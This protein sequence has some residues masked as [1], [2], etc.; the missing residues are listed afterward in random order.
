MPPIQIRRPM[1]QDEKLGYNAIIDGYAIIPVFN[2]I[3]RNIH[4]DLYFTGCPYIYDKK[5]YRYQ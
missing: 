5:N 3:D 1:H 2:Y 4:D